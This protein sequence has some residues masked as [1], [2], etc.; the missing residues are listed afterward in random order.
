MLK[1]I[2]VKNM[3]KNPVMINLIDTIIAETELN[4]T[5][6]KKRLSKLK[7]IRKECLDDLEALTKF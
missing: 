3:S 4:I 5:L 7:V 2:G 1:N 6:S